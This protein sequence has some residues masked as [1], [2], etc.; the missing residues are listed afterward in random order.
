[1]STNFP[2]SSVLVLKAGIQST[3]QDLGRH[4]YRHLG[5]AQSGALDRY[6]LQL[7]NKLVGNPENAAGL[8]IVIGPVEIQFHRDSWFALCGANFGAELDGQS[9][10]KA[11]RH[12]ARAGQILKLQGAFNES[13]V[14]L[15]IDGGIINEP[16]LG[17]RSTNLQAGLGGH[18]GRALQ[19]GDLL[20]LG[21]AQSYRRSV[22]VQQ[23]IWTPEVRAIRGPEF[24]QFDACSQ[25]KFWQQAW[26]VSSQS[27][28]MAYRLIGDPML[29]TE[30]NDLASHAVFPGVIQVPSN[31]QAIVLLAD[32]QTTGGYPR[33]A[34]VI[35]ADLWKIAQTPIGQHFCFI[36]VTAD[37]AHIAQK[38]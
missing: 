14:Y 25:K 23:R 9:K 7:A 28:R 38:K 35:E 22:G 21:K 11:W 8:E 37:V 20:A 13:R 17:S 12:F 33:I 36:E 3:V 34:C 19:K 2:T 15:A 29:R 27:N 6:S 30:S 5:I 26:K 16:V 18:H 1:M 10:A 24:A 31:G 4:G 32:C